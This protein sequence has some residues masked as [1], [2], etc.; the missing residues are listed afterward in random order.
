MIK[1]T[2]GTFEMPPWNRKKVFSIPFD[3]GRQGPS[4]RNL[5][6]FVVDKFSLSALLF[7]R[8]TYCWE[9][10]LWKPGEASTDSLASFCGGFQA[11]TRFS[12]SSRSIQK[13][14]KKET[15]FLIIQFYIENEQLI[16]R[17]QRWLCCGF[18]WNCKKWGKLPFSP[19]HMPPLLM[20][21]VMNSL[22]LFNVKLWV[23]LTT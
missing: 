3:S 4:N 7:I 9:T 13:K 21:L 14:K 8:N 5:V 11:S 1:P 20:P 17:K 12:I 15:Q 22:W 19:P 16:P 10:D 18:N 23:F 2:S 6:F